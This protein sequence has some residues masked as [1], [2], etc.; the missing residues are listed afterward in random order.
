MEKLVMKKKFDSKIYRE[1]GYTGKVDDLGTM[2]C[3][4]TLVI[5]RGG[6][7]GGLLCN[8]GGEYYQDMG[9]WFDGNK[10]LTDYD[11]A[12]HLPRQGAEMIREAG[13]TV[14]EDFE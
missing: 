3:E 2:E 12:F 11:G 14:S 8:Y 6:K 5:H 10:A 4:F 7:T 1:H 13:F 9:L